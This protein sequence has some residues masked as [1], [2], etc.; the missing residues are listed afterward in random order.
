ML[1]GDR[2]SVAEQVA[3][4]LGIDEVYSDLLPADKVEQMERLF[5]EKSKKSKLVLWEM[6]L[7]TLLF[8]QELTLELQW[9]RLVPMLQLKLQI[10]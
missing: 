8:W 4:D 9:V 1:T 2:K 7:M 5:A 3:N 6:A 10:L